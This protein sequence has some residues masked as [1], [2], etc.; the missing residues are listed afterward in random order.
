MPMEINIID[1]IT[2][3]QELE[4]E[5]HALVESSAINMPFLSYVYQRNWWETIGGGEWPA[6]N[7]SLRIITARKAGKLVGIAPL[8]FTQ[9]QG[10]QPALHFIG[11]YEVSDYLDFIV[12][13]E[14][15]A[16]FIPAVLSFLH[17]HPDSTN[18]Q[19]DLYNILDSSSS[20]PIIREQ[21]SL[22]HWEYQEEIIQPSPYLSIP[23]NWDQYM[24][25]LNKKYRHEIRRKLRRAEETEL[26]CYVVTDPL[27]LDEEI[28]SFIEMM[29]LDPEKEA[30]LSGKMREH[31]MTTAKIAFE[32]G[33]LHLAYLTI[34]N[35][36]AA[37]Y[38]NFL[39]NN[40][41]L[42]FNSS[43]NR[44]F[45]HYSPGWVLLAKVIKWAIKH[46]VKIV[47]FMRGDEAY[48]YQF[49][50]VDRFV[51]RATLSL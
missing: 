38:M 21:A 18:K 34:N 49:G 3:W 37:S 14:D 32:Q 22:N 6:D 20:L 48:K 25:T 39:I 17:Q 16:E 31:I 43:W 36:K 2:S 9:K 19:L 11:S 13:E 45:S 27:T 44:N 24:A 35:E 40:H 12:S 47:D 50:G 1:N 5:W 51:I 15:T 46:D 7:S 29:A 4:S 41:L 23:E 8:F 33:W 10:H 28:N 30:F 26:H 42:I